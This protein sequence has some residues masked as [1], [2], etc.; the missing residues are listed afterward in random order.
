MRVASLIIF[1]AAGCHLIGGYDDFNVVDPAA[2]GSGATSA[3]GDGAS[4]AGGGG[5]QPCTS[6]DDCDAPASPCQEASCDNNMCGASNLD[7]GTECPIGTCDDM[8]VCHCATNADCDAH[9][10]CTDTVACLSPYKWAALVAPVSS[11]KASI[12]S[13][14][15]EDGGHALIGFK[16]D[17]DAQL[18]TDNAVD[19]TFTSGAGENFTVLSL[20]DANNGAVRW[21]A[22]FEATSFFVGEP[23]KVA[24]YGTGNGAR[25][26]VAGTFSSTSLTVAGD[27]G[28]DNIDGI[29]DDQAFV[30]TV[31]SGAPA[32][33]PIGSDVA[34]VFVE[35]VACAN[36]CVVVGTYANS[37]DLNLG[38]G[39][40]TAPQ[41]AGTRGGFAI[42]YA[43][44]LT[45]EWVRWFD[46]DTDFGEELYVAVTPTH[47]Y[48][49]FRFEGDLTVTECDTCT[50]D[51]MGDLSSVP[52]AIGVVQ[53]DVMTGLT[54]SATKNDN[55]A[56]RMLI[57]AAPMGV[58]MAAS[59]SGINYFGTTFP[60]AIQSDCGV[61]FLEP[62]LNNP[63]VS[64]ITGEGFQ[65]C[66]GQTNDATSIYTAVNNGSG[67]ALTI[68]PVNGPAVTSEE[69]GIA[70][71]G[72][73]AA[74]AL[75]F[76]KLFAIDVPNRGASLGTHPM[77]GHAL[78]FEVGSDSAP[79]SVTVSD[80]ISLAVPQC[81]SML[82]CA[83]AIV[84]LDPVE[85]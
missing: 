33:S 54:A 36:R 66:D 18:L 12:S 35:R 20:D 34:D 2:G 15:V 21:M 59:G 50:A 14:A 1:I 84:R 39:A 8:G 19:P 74:G 6:P 37:F 38:V 69:G 81:E 64:V 9:Q 77:F 62:N 32:L 73:T 26:F 45:A 23:P 24:S 42:G 40:R 68:T 71:I 72:W 28:P 4:S 55:N 61:A 80:A 60:D 63:A 47:A 78:T 7:A 3:G 46:A 51:P 65:S 49:D 10:I 76:A 30:A 52:G 79:G 56:T 57:A 11:G 25:A 22:T 31:G 82:N 5:A 53:L 85:P 48:V 43:T 75:R 44:D 16:H 67:E 29:D 70:L 58:G 83:S 41:P 13:V 27:G 17:T